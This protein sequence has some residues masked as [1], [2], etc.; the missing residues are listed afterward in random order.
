MGFE[1]VPFPLMEAL[2]LYRLSSLSYR[3]FFLLPNL[4]LTGIPCSAQVVVVHVLLH[5]LGE[6][7]ALGFCFLACFFSDE[8]FPHRRC[9]ELVF[10]EGLLT[11]SSCH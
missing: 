7:L 10:T 6:P 9:G 2:I 1:V 4:L 8:C 3:P 11:S 5:E